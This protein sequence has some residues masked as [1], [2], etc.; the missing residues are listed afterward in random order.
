M[1]AAHS[2]GLA[3]VLTFVASVPAYGAT[4][5]L[6]AV[7][8]GWYNNSGFH[9]PTNPNY[10]VG[11]GVG[12]P[13]PPLFR[14]FFIFDLSSLAGQT[15]L[16]ARLVLYNPNDGYFSTNTTE[17]FALFDVT[18]D[19]AVLQAGGAG[20]T[21]I[22]D[23]LGSGTSYGSRFVGEATEGT[24]VFTTLNADGVTAVNAALGGSF[25]I[26]GTLTTLQ[27]GS[28][29][30][31]MFSGTGDLPS[32]LPRQLILT[33]EDVGEPVPEPATLSLL[34]LGLGAAAVRR[35]MKGR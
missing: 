27:L 24:P 8:T 32:F 17:T 21:S 9:D 14:D 20:L 12:V 4:I 10:I 29:P 5:V 18:T 25:A 22:Y 2:F 11:E 28:P 30:E 33:V 31:F 35:R 34:G 15:V 13:T 1:R 19:I 7:D 6:S 3:V 16:S 26:G 23:D